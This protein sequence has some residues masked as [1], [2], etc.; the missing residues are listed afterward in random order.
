MAR[1]MLGQ[2]G[3][4]RSRGAQ[5]RLV[6]VLLMLLSLTAVPRAALAQDRNDRAQPWVRVKGPVRPG[7]TL[8]INAWC[9]VGDR[10]AKQPAPSLSG[11]E[12]RPIEMAPTNRGARMRG[13]LVLGPD[14]H[15]KSV[16]VTLHCDPQ[17]EVTVVRQARFSP[18]DKAASLWEE[19][20]PLRG[21]HR[22]AGASQQNAAVAVAAVLGSFALLTGSFLFLIP[23]CRRRVGARRRSRAEADA[24]TER[25]SSGEQQPP[26][27]AAA[28]EENPVRAGAP[29]GR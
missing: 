12:G 16:S 15:G 14:Y 10:G 21:L 18:L 23:A 20:S 24:S 4:C 28:P 8:R 2:G 3:S 19:S 25:M 22:W 13:T 6:M 7:S 11:P 26:G 1:A 17:T 9:P 5:L 29:Q 27:S